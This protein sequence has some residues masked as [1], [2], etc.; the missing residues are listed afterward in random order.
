L[1]RQQDKRWLPRKVRHKLYH[2]ILPQL[3]F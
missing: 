2:G 3:H 1:S